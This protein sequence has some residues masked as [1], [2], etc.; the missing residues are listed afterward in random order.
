V[1]RYDFRVAASR[2]QRGLAKL[3]WSSTHKD[4]GFAEL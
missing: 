2:Q 4:A 1:G 3:H